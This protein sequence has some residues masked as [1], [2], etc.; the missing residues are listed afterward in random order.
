MKKISLKLA[1][2]KAGIDKRSASWKL[3]YLKKYSLAWYK[4][5]VK[6][7]KNCYKLHP[8][9]ITYLKK[10]LRTSKNI[11]DLS[12]IISKSKS[13]GPRKVNKETDIK[14]VIKNDSEINI[15]KEKNTKRV[16]TGG[17]KMGTPNRIS[18]DIRK[19]IEDIILGLSE[20]INQ[21]LQAVLPKER[22]DF[23]IKALP[24]NI[25]KF[26]PVDKDPD[27]VPDWQKE[28]KNI[29]LRKQKMLGIFGSLNKGNYGNSFS[30]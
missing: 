1:A 13:S 2:E 15:E 16:K 3:S 11:T 14:K 30:S 25:P 17:R 21:D 8:D 4:K 22:L 7:E 12:D 24:Y 18:N 27:Q 9:I 6:K 23:Y 26:N 5:L 10:D 19:K 29:D 20:N 28:F